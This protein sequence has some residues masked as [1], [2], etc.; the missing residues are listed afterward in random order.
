MKWAEYDAAFRRWGAVAQ[1][2]TVDEM[3]VAG[4]T[5]PLMR[6]QTDGAHDLLVT[7]GFHGDETA[8]PLTLLAHLPDLVARARRCRVGLTIFPCVNPSGFEVRTRYNEAQEA[9]NNDFLRYEV[10][11]GQTKA[12]VDQLP[13]GQSACL[14]WRPFLEGPAETQAMARQLAALPTPRAMLDLHQD[15]WLA[16]TGCYAYVFGDRDPFRTLLTRSDDVLPLARDAEVDD[17]LFSDAEALI[18]L[19]DGSI[20]DLF[21]RRGTPWVATLET[22]TVSPAPACSRV[23]MIWLEGFIDLAARRL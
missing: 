6:A 8:G 3:K 15:P 9:P 13:H 5:Y 12:W 11:Q 22:T 10:V 18:E 2:E 21:W 16:K 14:G 7:A 23:N 19:H 20:T 4:R 1:V 17:D